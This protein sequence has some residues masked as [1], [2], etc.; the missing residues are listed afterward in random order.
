MCFYVTGHENFNSSWRLWLTSKVKKNGI[1]IE[2]KQIETRGVNRGEFRERK[3]LVG[4]L[5]Q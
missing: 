3:E 2:N 1:L 5:S 4:D